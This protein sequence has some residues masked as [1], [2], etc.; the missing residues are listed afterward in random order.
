MASLIFAASYL[1]IK[2]IKTK[3][4]E[5]K[6]SKRR[7]YA[8]RYAELEREHKDFATTQFHGQGRTGDSRGE[9]ELQDITTTHYVERS[10]R[11]R[12]S[13][14]LRRPEEKPD[15]STSNRIAG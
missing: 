4:E 6:D 7:A 9:A 14:S 2:K 11:S 12:S 1:T 5:K 3:R 15:G 8:D 13:E 10:A